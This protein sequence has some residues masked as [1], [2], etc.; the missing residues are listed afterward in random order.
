MYR[1]LYVGE[2]FHEVCDECGFHGGTL[3][4]PSTVAR[5]RSL[6][7]RW[8]A[9]TTQDEALLR[10]R[11]EPETWCVVEYAQHII[12]A[13]ASIEWAARVFASGHAPK[14]DELS[15]DSVPG[16]FEHPVHDCAR[17]T[18]AD[19]IESLRAVTES[20]ADF[21]EALTPQEQAHVEVYAEGWTI[22]TTAVIRHA[23][24]DAEHHLLD[25]RRGIARM[26]LRADAAEVR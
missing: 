18:V 4:L 2:E 15:E 1:I 17:F 11:P 26:Q 6:P 24:H 22:N 16:A 21:A 10:A 13:I 20:M 14:W 8:A 5:L 12:N 25:V 7:D 9:V 19:T 3:D 23:L